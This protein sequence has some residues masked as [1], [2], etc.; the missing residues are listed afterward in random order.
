V[1]HDQ[2]EE[3]K[4]TLKKQTKQPFACDIFQQPSSVK[5]GKRLTRLGR[6]RFSELDNSTPNSSPVFL[7]I[8]SGSAFLHRQ[9]SPQSLHNSSLGAKP[10]KQE[11]KNA[12]KFASVCEQPNVW[13]AKL[14][15]GRDA[16]TPEDARQVFLGCETIRCPSSFLCGF[17]LEVRFLKV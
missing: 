4:Q 3:K 15:A 10:F 2:T 13:L 11:I 14:F 12:R 17:S 1:C 6:L 7:R 8:K 9:R 5:N 16:A